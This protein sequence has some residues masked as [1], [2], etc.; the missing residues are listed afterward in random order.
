VTDA[1]KAL[2]DPLRRLI[3]DELAE[4]D[5]QTLFEL[6]SRLALKHQNTSTRQAVSH[7]LMLLEKAGI[8][9]T[10]RQGRTKSHHLQPDSLQSVTQRWAD[11]HTRGPLALRISQTS[12]FVDDQDRALEFYTTKL[13]FAIHADEPAGEHRWIALTAPGDPRGPMLVLEP[14]AHPA[15]QSLKRSLMDEGTP[16]TAFAVTDIERAHV[17][18]V[19][20]GVVFTQ[21]PVSIGPMTSAVLNDTC[22]NLLQLNSQRLRLIDTD[23]GTTP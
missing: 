23:E 4:R 22:G 1:F 21:P 3:V 20:R 10:R 11:L 7:H 14:D 2:S 18:L 19:A 12:V 13:G 15:I 9:T 8:I 17:E 5:G 16:F 6:C